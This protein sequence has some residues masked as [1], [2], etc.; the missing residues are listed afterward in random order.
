MEGVEEVE[1]P[2]EKQRC[3][4]RANHYYESLDGINS[5]YGSSLPWVSPVYGHVF[6]GVV[7]HSGVCAT[8]LQDALSVLPKRLQASREREGQ[9]W[10]ECIG[11]ASER[12]APIF[13][14]AHVNGRGTERC[15]SM[16]GFDCGDQLSCQCSL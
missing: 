3:G 6:D 15:G 2:S 16:V 8:S 13:V 12:E 14:A 4:E 7:Q 10:M 9:R 1:K 11:S 5:S